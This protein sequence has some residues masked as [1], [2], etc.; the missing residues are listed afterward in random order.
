MDED[1]SKERDERIPY[2][3][4]KLGLSRPRSLEEM[5]SNDIKIVEATLDEDPLFYLCIDGDGELVDKK[6]AEEYVRQ[7]NESEGFD[8]SVYP[9]PIP[10]ARIIPL[11]FEKDP[12]QHDRLIYLSKLA[13]D[14]FNKDNIDAKGTSYEF[15]NIEKVTVYDCKGYIYGITFR[16]QQADTADLKTFQAKDYDD[17]IDEIEEVEFIHMK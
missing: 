2:A 10:I 15:V 12:E 13:L 14:Q 17:F 6:L 9:G 3:L 16:A 1:G 8:V 11:H 5:I 4:L 7:V